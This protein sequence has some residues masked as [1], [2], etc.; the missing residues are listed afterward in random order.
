MFRHLR[1]RSRDES[2]VAIVAAMA[3]AF[4]VMSLMIIVVVMTISAVNNSGRDR[5]RTEAIH[6]AEGA[7]DATMAELEH[8][9]PCGGPSFSPIVVGTGSQST[10][11][12]VQIEYYKDDFTTR[13]YCVGGVPAGDPK[14]ALVRATSRPTT[15]IVGQEPVRVLEATLAVKARGGAYKLPGIYAAQNLYMEGTPDVFSQP[16][17]GSPD[18][19]IDNGSFYCTPTTNRQLEV[20]ADVVVVN[21]N[22]YLQRWCWLDRDVYVGGN[23]TFKQSSAS[24]NSQVNYRCNNKFICGDFTGTGNLVIDSNAANL[25][26]AGDVTLGG[27]LTTAARLRADGAVR[28]RVPDVEVKAVR[29]FPSVQYNY[30]NWNNSYGMQEKFL[31]GS[32]GFVSRLDFKSTRV[33]NRYTCYWETYNASNVANCEFDSQYYNSTINLPSTPT[34]Y[35]LRESVSGCSTIKFHSTNTIVVNADTAFMVSG[36]YNDGTLNFVS[37]DGARHSVWIIVPDTGVPPYNGS[38]SCSSPTRY[39]LCS[40]NVMTSTADVPIMWYTKHL[41]YSDGQSPSVNDMYGQMF[42]GSVYLKGYLDLQ[43]DTL[44]IPGEILWEAGDSGFDVQLLGKR[45]VPAP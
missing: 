25:T 28:T 6:S 33:C 45:E 8:S 21:G 40:T 37:G 2:G 39:N 4:I 12:T 36:F 13:V 23:T 41:F 19:W 10:T 15:A 20:E 35:D 34:V 5:V 3:V 38:T 24:S 44:T 16:D 7:V 29:G 42:A 11:V 9:I 32:D 31:G 27:N 22:A 30:S 1:T 17:D 14:F 18:I 43:F 26:T